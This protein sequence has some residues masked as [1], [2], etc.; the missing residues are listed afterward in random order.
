MKHVN[1]VDLCSSEGRPK[2]DREYVRCQKLHK[3]SGNTQ[4]QNILPNLQER[5][6]TSLLHKSAIR[7][8]KQSQL[9]F[10]R[11]SGNTS[12]TSFKNEVFA[13]LAGVS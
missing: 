12:L 2:H 11:N 4:T 3:C 1:V 13:V 9:A 7:I 8:R 5:I 10:R 6:N